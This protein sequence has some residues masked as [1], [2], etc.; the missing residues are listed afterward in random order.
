M[1][2]VGETEGEGVLDVEETIFVAVEKNVKKSKKTLFWAAENFLG[3]KI[4]LLHV[5]QP[6]HV[7]ALTDGNFSHQDLKQNAIEA[8]QKLERQKRHELLDDYLP[9]LDQAGVQADKILIEMDNIERGIVEA[10]AQYNIRW[11]VMGAA[12]DKYHSMELTG[13]KSKKAIF[14]CQEA[15]ISCH[16]WFACNGYLIYTRIGRKDRYEMET[17]PRKQLLDSPAGTEQYESA[18]YSLS[19]LDA[20]EVAEVTQCSEHPSCSNNVVVGTSSS[21]SFL[22]DEEEDSQGQESNEADQ[23]LELATGAVKRWKEEDVALE[24]KCKARALESLCAKE[25]SLRKELEE[26]L[27]RD[28]QE[29]LRTKNQYDGFME[30][31][32]TVNDRKAA[33]EDRLAESQCMVKE[34]EEKII[35]AVDLLI[36][37]KKQRDEM[38]VQH[39][40]A[41]RELN[42]SRKLASGEAES[43]YGTE[44]LEFSFMEINN[45]TQDFDPSFRIGDGKYGSVYKGLLCHLQVAIKMLPSYGSQSLIEFQNEVE[46]LSRVRHPNLVTLVG[47]CPESRS[48]VYEYVRNGSLE[49]CLLCSDNTPLLWETRTRIAYDICSALIF[50]HSNKPC[51]PHG[52]L[53]PSKVLLDTNF[54]CKLSDFGIYRLISE[55][56]SGTSFNEADPM[57]ASAYMAPEYLQTGE[58][59]PE[60]DLYSF[61]MVLLQL[62]TGRPV[63][64]VLKDVK[65]ALENGHLNM[66]LDASAGDWPL[67]Q[68]QQL[69]YLA[70]R[71]CKKNPLNRPDLVS[72]IR[73]VLEPMMDSCLSPASSL[74]VKKHRRVPSHFVC[75]IFQ[76][77]M[78]DPHI[79]A[80]GFT[81]EADAIRGWFKSGHDTSPMTN[82]KLQHCNLLPNHALH[83][84]I[85]EW[86]Q[87]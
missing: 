8:F 72:E 7:H 23:K 21:I 4:C 2:T 42:Y 27:V 6:T 57:V 29:V 36:S 66:L 79:A 38:R 58:V 71:C 62:L 48:L 47:T 40:D 10:I 68:A 32:Q 37:F 9:L 43:F 12:A 5:Y 64:G 11:L 84:A 33:L 78:K 17:V 19:F 55:G 83:Q 34:L 39:G 81:Y 51:L 41:R 46:V 25:M 44:I 22:R 16:I 85:Q 63:M 73:T 86:R 74:R 75:P 35:S 30:E 59:T 45:A 24:A 80:D 20:G 52:N 13:L 50:L 76:E 26:L 69:A 56:N 70:L 14:V 18:V 54:V 61:G 49:D 3:R 77:V 87:K 67:A 31:L 65:C 82:L 1:G 53:K 15:Q 28:K 60:S